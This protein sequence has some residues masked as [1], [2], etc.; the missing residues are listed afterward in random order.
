MTTRAAEKRKRD[1]DQAEMILDDPADEERDQAGAGPSTGWRSQPGRGSGRGGRGGWGGRVARGGRGA[2]GGRGN[3]SA[4]WGSGWGA[5][6]TEEGGT[7]GTLAGT[8]PRGAGTTGPK[9]NRSKGATRDKQTVRAGL[10]QTEQDE[11]GKR[12]DGEG[13][14]GMEEEVKSG[15]SDQPLLTFGGGLPAAKKA[16]RK[17]DKLGQGQG[18]K[19]GKPAGKGDGGKSAAKGRGGAKAGGANEQEKGGGEDVQ[20]QKEATLQKEGNS[21]G[22]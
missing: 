11:G 20:P 7:G 19:K 2:G 13:A 18:A 1:A 17:S 9:G 15:N 4:G 21:E 16:R 22:D 5:I 8:G 12:G 6:D 3:S 10:S 14:L